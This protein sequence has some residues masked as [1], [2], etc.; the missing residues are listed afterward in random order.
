MDGRGKK[1]PLI[2]L[3]LCIIL[4]MPVFTSGHE[5]PL[6]APTDPDLTV[7]DIWTTKG[8]EI[9]CRVKNIGG[10]F[11]GFFGVNLTI[12]GKFMETE[13]VGIT[14]PDTMVNVTFTNLLPYGWIK[15]ALKVNIYD[16]QHGIPDQNRTN[17]E[18]TERWERDLPNLVPISI[19]ND[20]ATGT[21]RIMVW[22]NGVKPTSYGFD[23]VLYVNGSEVD[24]VHWKPPISP[25][26]TV[27]L[28]TTWKWDRAVSPVTIK[29]TADEGNVVEESD[30][31]DNTLVITWQNRP[32]PTFTK[33]PTVQYTGKNNATIVWETSVPTDSVVDYGRSSEL[34][35]TTMT[36]ALS[37]KGSAEISSLSS[38]TQYLY[39]IVCTDQYGKKVES[40]IG[41]LLTKTPSPTGSPTGS[42]VSELLR[43]VS[44]KV[45]IPFIGSDPTGIKKVDFYLDGKLIGS[46]GGSG[47]E[48]TTGIVFDFSSVKKGDHTMVAV[49]TNLAG[50]TTRFSSECSVEPLISRLP[51]VD[52]TVRDTPYSGTAFFY[53]RCTDDSGIANATW[54]VDDVQVEFDVPLH[55]EGTFYGA[56]LYFDTTTVS[57]GDHEIELRVYNNEGYSVTAI[58]SFSTD[59]ILD[60]PDPDIWVRRLNIESD[61]TEITV[62]LEVSNHGRG[63]ARNIRIVDNIKGF[64]P[65]DGEE[66]TVPASDPGL[67]WEVV[68]EVDHLDPGDEVVLRYRCI[69]LLYDSE[70]WTIGW[71]RLSGEDMFTTSYTYERDDGHIAYS[72]RTWIPAMNFADGYIMEAGVRRAIGG[73]NYLMLTNPQQLMDNMAFA[74][75]YFDLF[76]SAGELLV[77]KNGV[78]GFI[79]NV[80]GASP[81]PTDILDR[82]DEWA[83]LLDPDFRD[84]GY[85]AI[86]GEDEI[87]PIW[88]YSNV[89]GSDQGYSNLDGGNAPKLIVGRFLGRTPEDLLVPIMS[90]LN[91]SR[92]VMVS[93]NDGRGLVVAG[94]GNGV[95][96]FHESAQDIR[97]TIGPLMDSCLMFHKS[98]YLVTELSSVQS[99]G[100]SRHM[101]AGDIDRDGDNE[102]L[103]I[104]PTGESVRILH[105]ETGASSQF[106]KSIDEWDTV[107]LY[108]RPAETFIGIM[109]LGDDRN[110]LNLYDTDGNLEDSY[111]TDDWQAWDGVLS[112]EQNGDG[113]SEVFFSSAGCDT[114]FRFDPPAAY[115]VGDIHT[116]SRMAASDM[117]DDGDLDIVLADHQSDAL[118]VFLWPPPAS[119]TWEELDIPVGGFDYE[120]GFGAGNFLPS[121]RNDR[122]EAVVLNHDSHG[123][124]KICWLDVDD[125]GDLVPKSEDSLL[126]NVEDDCALWVSPTTNPEND[127]VLVTTSSDHA[128]VM[129]Y[130]QCGQ[131]FK[132]AVIPFMTDRDLMVYRDHGNEAAWSGLVGSNDLDTIGITSE[133]H[134]PVMIGLVCLSGRFHDQTNSFSQSAMRNGAG[135]YIGATMVSSR[136]PNN[137]AIAMIEDY[138]SGTPIGKAL[139]D[140][141]VEYS[142]ADTSSGLTWSRMYNLYGDPAFGTDGSPLGRGSRGPPSRAGPVD[143]AIPE[144]E[145]YN[146]SDGTGVGIQGGYELY[147]IGHPILPFVVQR[148]P[149]GPGAGV[150]SVE[151]SMTGEWT[152]YQALSMPL[153]TGPQY[154]GAGATSRV[155]MEGDPDDGFYPI[156]TSNWSVVAGTDGNDL[157]VRIFPFEYNVDSLQGRFCSSWSISYETE[158]CTVQI[159][160][161]MS[162][163]PEAGIVPFSFELVGS[164]GEEVSFSAWIS[165]DGSVVRELSSE[166]IYINGTTSFDDEWDTAGSDPG[167][168]EFV[169]ELRT[170]GGN[171]VG[172][173]SLPFEVGTVDVASPMISLDPEEFENETVVNVTVHFPNPNVLETLEGRFEIGLLTNLSTPISEMNGTISI[174]SG[175]NVS[176]FTEFDMT[177]LTSDRYAVKASI[178]GDGFQT[179]SIA[180]LVRNGTGPVT[181]I[182]HYLILDFALNATEIAEG[183]SF[184]INGT[185]LREDSFAI[186]GLPVAAWIGDRERSNS[187]LTG[188]DGTFSVQLE[189]LSAGNWTG[190]IVSEAGPSMRVSTPFS[191]TVLSVPVDNGTG[192]DDDDNVTD[193]DD[194]DDNITDDDDDNVTDDDDTDDEDDDRPDDDDS[195][196]LAFVLIAIVALSVIIL[197]FL[198]I[199]FLLVVMAR[200]RRTGTGPEE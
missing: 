196:G 195:T 133:G 131:R 86:L 172:A 137:R 140:Y 59:N 82:I 96:P 164:S 162:G 117:D 112:F 199:I 24:T 183:G 60:P 1:G 165:M 80:G 157:L 62:P 134:H 150:T 50:E 156:W 116:N 160:N 30:E 8:T 98:T 144:P 32:R 68:L 146:V 143:V 2:V 149:L 33:P 78:F 174:A 54:I 155:M 3:I 70:E 84:D 25:D 166:L 122:G 97:D 158:A 127:Q 14:W 64:I 48:D 147:E 75:G 198:V 191:I 95:F 42:F 52:F 15:V 194:D 101:T 4:S 188:T 141:E 10:T 181:P 46:K 73:S 110:L 135:I 72:E 87:I 35:Q 148:V 136:N 12:D 71:E 88:T 126:T 200:S 142:A 5:M 108:E 57:D 23:T 197:L 69:P 21:A 81:G 34:T 177:G 16:P 152:Y 163:E 89:D 18:R 31:T 47:K 104:D 79:Q 36:K 74:D 102:I 124:F 45:A 185:V 85:L 41:S 90:S 111:G 20:P 106:T 159:G 182:E 115:V 114:I 77:E 66:G 39:K 109:T 93:E 13:V 61:G 128:F 26:Q 190:T 27:T 180:W 138:V 121:S 184:W 83:D 119:G 43:N 29:V 53:A 167:T 7:I 153:Y 169:I 139:R 113:Y 100:L 175:G 120:D 22:N 193:D 9:N 176:R 170:G 92:G 187:T 40:S 105:P 67:R 49:M 37:K 129:D 17:D 107:F 103:T 11:S 151:V 125:S 186:P 91:V 154:D 189:N 145:F 179:S 28:N 132:D 123:Y 51:K 6:R 58:R 178:I 38:S 168:Y 76:S 118:R 130:G 99:D 63:T 44:G 94:A 161:V 173:Y 19:F 55:T 192:D 65:I 171:F 56:N